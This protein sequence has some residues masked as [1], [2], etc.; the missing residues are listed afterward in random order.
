MFG[1]D[2][3]TSFSATSEVARG[4]PNGWLVYARAAVCVQADG[5][6]F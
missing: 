6:L 4:S 3:Q 1:M 2:A 5:G